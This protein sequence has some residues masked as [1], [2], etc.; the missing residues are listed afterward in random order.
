M[1]IF[2]FYF[3]FFSILGVSLM[4]LFIY[5]EMKKKTTPTFHQFTHFFFSLFFNLH[6]YFSQ[7]SLHI[8]IAYYYLFI[9]THTKFLLLLSKRIRCC[10]DDIDDVFKK[11][12]TKNK[13][14]K[15][16]P[17]FKPYSY[18]HKSLR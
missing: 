15:L 6:L 2:S 7:C 4:L 12:N 10:L 13:P 9:T 14:K 11:K 5:L 18:C 16:F 3:S 1:Q 17:S 8:F